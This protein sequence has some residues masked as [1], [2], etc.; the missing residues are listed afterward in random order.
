L[1]NFVP[2]EGGLWLTLGVLAFLVVMALVLWRRLVYWHS[3]MEVS[4]E[5]SLAPGT[6]KSGP[7]WIDRY[8]PWGLNIGEVILPNR[9]AFAGKSIG[10][11]GLRTRFGCSVISVERQGFNL[12]NPGPASH[13]FSDDRVLLLGTDAQIAA[14]RKYLLDEHPAEQREDTFRDLAVELV[15]IPADSRAVDQTL[16]ALNWPRLLGVQV[17]GHERGEERTITPVGDLHLAAG[18]RVLVLGTPAQ[19]TAL[20]EWLG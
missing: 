19:M 2:V 6:A 12:T 1:W 11:L 13:L 16:A 4:L 8:A 3:T 10:E 17:V 15:D 20:R 9:F 7:A 14:A 5:A 18:D